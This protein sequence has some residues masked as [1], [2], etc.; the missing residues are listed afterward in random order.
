MRTR[1]WTVLPKA[2]I[3]IIY[4]TVEVLIQERVRVHFALLLILWHLAASLILRNDR[5]LQLLL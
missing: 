4:L 1:V 3:S 2:Y 5:W